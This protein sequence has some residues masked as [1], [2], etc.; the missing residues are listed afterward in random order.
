MAGRGF[1]V[2]FKVPE[3]AQALKQIDNYDG[4]TRL[5]VEEAVSTSTKAIRKGAIKR[6]RSATGYL[7]KH[8]VSNFIKKDIVGAIRAKAPHAHLVEFGARAATTKPKKEKA[9]TIDEFG[10]RRYA[11][12][13]KIPAR[14][15]RP[16]MRPAYEDEKPNLIKKLSQAVKKT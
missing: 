15:E 10:L 12:V 7:K 1:Y 8:T 2:N 6:I 11:K 9:L 3:I 13:A 16:Y 14:V 4:K 5:K